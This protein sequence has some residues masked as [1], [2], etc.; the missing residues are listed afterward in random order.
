MSTHQCGNCFLQVVGLKKC[1]GCAYAHY[2]SRECQAA[3]WKKHKLVC[4]K[5]A[6]QYAFLRA[7]PQTQKAFLDTVHVLAHCY[8]RKFNTSCCLVELESNPGL[9]AIIKNI[10]IHSILDAVQPEDLP[11]GMDIYASFLNTGYLQPYTGRAKVVFLYKE[12]MYG[13]SSA[14]SIKIKAKTETQINNADQIFIAL[15][16]GEVAVF[17]VKGD[18]Y[19]RISFL[20]K[21]G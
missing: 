4:T 15:K 7:L 17:T 20:M 10:S 16:E 1:S 13:V 21:H 8:A 9:G 11:R 14:V 6:E 19:E 3:D 18:T 5:I 12:L 2:C